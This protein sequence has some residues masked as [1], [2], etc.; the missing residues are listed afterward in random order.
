MLY[1]YLYHYTIIIIHIIIISSLSSMIA[2]AEGCPA[3]FAR[4]GWPSVC[5][6]GTLTSPRLNAAK[7]SA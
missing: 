4:G 6:G 2:C 1:D 7:P 3:K 5:G